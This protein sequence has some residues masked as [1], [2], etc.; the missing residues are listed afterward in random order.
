MQHRSRAAAPVIAAAI[1]AGLFGA[2]P[3]HAAPAVTHQGQSDVNGD[4]YGDLVTGSEATVAG[5]SR[6]GA[7]VV[8]T[9]SSSGVSATRTKVIT[10]NTAGVPGAAEAGDRFGSAVVTG[11]LNGDGY[12]DVVAGTPHEKVG[13]DVDGGTVAVLWGS[14]SGISGGT[15]IADPAPTAHDLFGDH[16]TIGDYDGDGRP[17]LAV[18]SSR[19]DVWIFSGIAKTSGAAAR[20][21]LVT[22]VAPDSAAYYTSLTSGDFDGDGRDDLVVGGRYDE[23]GSF[24]GAAL[25][26]PGASGTY[27]ALPDE[28]PAAAA[29]DVDGDGVDD[30]VLGSPDDNK[31]TVYAGGASGLTAS[32]RRTFTQETPGVAGATED[33]DSFGDT[34]ATGDV[35][36]DGYADV[37]VGNDFETIGSGSALNSGEAVVLYGSADGLTGTGA[38]VLHQGTAGVPGANE[39]YDRFG[40][41]VRLTDTNRDGYADLAVAAPT[42]NKSN[43]ALWSL[44]GSAKGVT[45]SQAV[46]FSA[47]TAKVSSADYTYFGQWMAT[48]AYGE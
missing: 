16:L 13:S 5:A 32:A 27:T 35:N 41:S 6:A 40:G 45:T 12:T 23:D 38:Q 28:A 21:E 33:A 2:A 34:V 39:G 48:D 7:L 20:R 37:A 47:A 25:V 26:Y 30:L 46:S 9:G 1:A 31:V 24:D 8:N 15:T 29:G 17:E 10:Q 44:R 22:G 14:S 3:A 19:N 43:G 36:H 42:E 11:D 18:G 4:G